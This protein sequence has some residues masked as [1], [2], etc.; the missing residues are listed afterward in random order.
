VRKYLTERRDRLVAKV[1]GKVDDQLAKLETLRTEAQQE[2]LGKL[3]EDQQVMSQL[4][5]I[6]G[7]NGSLGGLNV[8]QIGSALNLDKLKR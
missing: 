3:G 4:A 8:P 6:M 2:L 5:S 1:Q 7:G